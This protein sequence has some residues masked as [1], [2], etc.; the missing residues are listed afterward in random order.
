MPTS[1]KGL[2]TLPHPPIRGQRLRVGLGE[3][4]T[5][6]ESVCSGRQFLIC[7][8]VEGDNLSARALQ[9]LQVL[10]VQE[11]ERRSCGDRHTDPLGPIQIPRL[12]TPGLDQERSCRTGKSNYSIK[13]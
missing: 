2:N 13:V 8:R 12:R 11:A 9:K 3:P 7:G 4:T 10:A 1:C 5:E 6:V